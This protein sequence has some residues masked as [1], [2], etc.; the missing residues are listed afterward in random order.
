MFLPKHWRSIHIYSALN[1]IVLDYRK[2]ISKY[3]FYLISRFI[4]DRWI[5]SQSRVF[6]GA[7]WPALKSY[8]TNIFPLQKSCLYYYKSSIVHTNTEYQTC[9]EK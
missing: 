6:F 1:I 9:T 2:I 3:I 8:W 7:H 4:I 5:F